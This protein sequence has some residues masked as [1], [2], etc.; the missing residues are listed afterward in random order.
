MLSQNFKPWVFRAPHFGLGDKEFVEQHLSKDQTLSNT[1]YGN[2]E[3][4]WFLQHLF[5]A[6]RQLR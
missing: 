1:D 2:H 4:S 5:L 6:L 3:H